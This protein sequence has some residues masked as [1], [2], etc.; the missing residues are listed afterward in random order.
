MSNYASSYLTVSKRSPRGCSVIDN[1]GGITHASD[2]SHTHTHTLRILHKHISAQTGGRE[3]HYGQRAVLVGFFGWPEWVAFAYTCFGRR[4][5]HASPHPLCF[6]YPC[7][8]IDIQY[9][10]TFSVVLQCLLPHC[11]KFKPKM[12]GLS[13]K[14]K[15]QK[16]FAAFEAVLL[17]FFFF[18]LTPAFPFPFESHVCIILDLPVL[19]IK[20]SHKAVRG[21]QTGDRV[22]LKFSYSTWFS[23]SKVLLLQG[24]YKYLVESLNQKR[25]GIFSHISLNLSR[26]LKY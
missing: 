17:F 14:S 26:F 24:L 3:L 18:W 13:L 12:Q 22:T 10:R 20:I 6:D 2:T 9:L 21:A 5:G 4:Y 1:P 15:M 25:V 7:F 23:P 16:A 11:F 8:D 19:H